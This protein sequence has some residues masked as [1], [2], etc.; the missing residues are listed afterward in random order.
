MWT[1]MMTSEG[2]EAQSP[3]PPPPPPPAPPAAP[4]GEE[5]RP[6]PPSPGSLLRGA[7]QLKR[8]EETHEAQPD[9]RSDLFKAIR[10]GKSIIDVQ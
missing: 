7:A 1:G 10:D 9:P 4:A 5:D 2:G 3:P 8:V 6:R